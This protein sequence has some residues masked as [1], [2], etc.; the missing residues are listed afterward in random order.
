[1]SQSKETT[2]LAL[3]VL[4]TAALAGG[5][6][7]FFT[8]QPKSDSISFTG[9]ESHSNVSPNAA[10]KELDLSQPNPT[11]LKTDGSTTMVATMQQLRTAFNQQYPNVP[12]TYGVPDNSPTGSGG[13]IKNLIHDQVSLAASSRSLKPEEAQY[14]IQM[15]PIAK[16]SVAVVVGIN[17]SFKGGLTLAQLRDIYTGKITNWS[18]VGGISAPIR[19][20]NRHSSSGTQ[21]FFKEVVLLGGKFAPDSSQFI[22][23]S[24]DETTAILRDLGDNS[25]SYATTSQVVNQEIVRIIPIDGVLPTDQNAIKSGKYPISRNLFLAVKKKTSPAVKQFLEFVPNDR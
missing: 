16:D 20:I 25:I 11:V 2:V 3:T 9:G 14:N 4:I 19:V 5:G 24:K 18:E 1:M 7:W 12:M 21:D 15:I 8:N 23:W 13:G 10:L 22:T 6:Y 17:N